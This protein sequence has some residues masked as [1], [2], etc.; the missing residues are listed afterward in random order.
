VHT[1]VKLLIDTGGYVEAW[2]HLY[3]DDEPKV[4]A[5]APALCHLYFFVMYV[6]IMWQPYPT[7]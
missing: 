2:G 7:L 6:G 5:Q 3:S 4:S 1:F